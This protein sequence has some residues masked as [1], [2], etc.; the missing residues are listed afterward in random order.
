[1]PENRCDPVDEVWLFP[2][3]DG[4]LRVD[5]RITQIGPQESAIIEL[6][7]SG[8]VIS[9]EEIAD[10]LWPGKRPK[11]HRQLI[12]H[13]MV[14]VR[15]MLPSDYVMTVYDKNVKLLGFFGRHAFS[16]LIGWQLTGKIRVEVKP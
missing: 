1:M 15:K 9:P 3:R 4:G 5:A 11:D 8:K 7:S 14:V 13:R 2:H 12:E 6:L 16:P 10:R